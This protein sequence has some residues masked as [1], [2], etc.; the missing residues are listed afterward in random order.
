MYGWEP[1]VVLWTMN[2]EQAIWW[3][4]TGWT[5]HWRKTGALP[6]MDE[7]PTQEDEGVDRAAIRRKYGGG[8]VRR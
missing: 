4:Q 6:F 7:E 3:W 5:T 2:A 1:R 8:N